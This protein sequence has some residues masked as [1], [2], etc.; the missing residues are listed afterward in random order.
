MPSAGGFGFGP[1]RLDLRVKQLL[2]DD[3]PVA[4][5]A[6]HYDL[7]VELVTRR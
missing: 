3:E 6:R 7:L 1:F 5:T 2:Q 4:L